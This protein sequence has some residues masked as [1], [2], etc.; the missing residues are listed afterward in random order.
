[1]FLIAA[2]VAD[3]EGI[4]EIEDKALSEIATALCVDKAALLGTAR[5]LPSAS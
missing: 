3:H 5:V 4:S 1:V 2:D